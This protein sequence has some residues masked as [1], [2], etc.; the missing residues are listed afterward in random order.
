MAKKRAPTNNG[1][2]VWLY[3]D[4]EHLNERVSRAIV[5]CLD[6]GYTYFGGRDDEVSNIVV[7]QLG[8]KLSSVD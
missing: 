8:L 3:T 4:A 7:L 1:G 5:R 6:D 2:R